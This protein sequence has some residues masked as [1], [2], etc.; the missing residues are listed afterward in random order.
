MT[1]RGLLTGVLGLGLLG[2]AASA[3][4]DKKKK[5][6]KPKKPARPRKLTRPLVT[7]ETSKGTV[8]LEL[9]PEEAPI[10]VGNFIE[11]IRKGFYNGLTFHRIE[12]FVAQGG[13]PKGD[14]SGGPGYAIK[15]EINSR[16]QHARGALGMANSGRDTGGSQFYIVKKDSFGLDNGSYT[17]FGKVSGGLDIVDKLV[18]G[19]KMVTVSVEAPQMGSTQPAQ[20]DNLAFPLLPDDYAKRQVVSGVRVR[21]QIGV[22]GGAGVVTLAR[23]CGDKELDAAVLDAIAA[24]RWTP[25]LKKGEPVASSQEFTYDLATFSRRYD[26]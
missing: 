22:Q 25:A 2:P 4:D 15:S 24:W 14:G 10:A 5:A 13:D 16:L 9:Y 21:I 8:L 11:L 26:N 17:L 18:K 6:E 1:R 7:I 19:D 20:P 3:A 12:D 23:S